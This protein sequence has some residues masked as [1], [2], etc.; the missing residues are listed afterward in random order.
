[1][2]RESDF[3]L[4][5]IV[6]LLDGI[7]ALLVVAVDGPF[8]RGNARVADVGAAGDIFLVPQQKVVPMLLANQVQEIA[9]GIVDFLPMPQVRGVAVQ[10]GDLLNVDHGACGAQSLTALHDG[11]GIVGFAVKSSKSNEAVIA[12]WLEAISL[13]AAAVRFVKCK[14]VDQYD[15]QR[16]AAMPRWRAIERCKTAFEQIVVAVGRGD[17]CGCS[18]GGYYRSRRCIPARRGGGRRQLR[19]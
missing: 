1:M 6:D 14:Y 16:V 18:V 2:P 12:G 19:S 10:C 7:V 17:D 15:D 5:I 8:H 4:Q 9:V 3:A 11:A 13:S